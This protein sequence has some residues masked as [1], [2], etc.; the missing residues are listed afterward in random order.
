M[1]KARRAR[2][3][4][5]RAAQ[6]GGPH[7][8]LLSSQTARHIIRLAANKTSEFD[9]Y[10]KYM[11]TVGKFILIPNPKGDVTRNIIALRK[12]RL[13]IETDGVL[14]SSPEALRQ[15]QGIPFDDLTVDIVESAGYQAM[16]SD[17]YQVS[18]HCSTSTSTSCKCT[19]TSSSTSVWG[20]DDDD[21]DEDESLRLG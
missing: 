5:A 21:D 4:K 20:D 1:A 7:H 9:L 17:T 16:F 8:I 6:R 15:I 12:T 14:V 3:A 10:D 2:R 13:L 18:I 19:S 11:N